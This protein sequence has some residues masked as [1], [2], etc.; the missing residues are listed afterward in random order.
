MLDYRIWRPEWH[1]RDYVVPLMN[2]AVKEAW[3]WWREVLSVVDNAGAESS[4]VG[5]SDSSSTT[6]RGTTAASVFMGQAAFNV[7]NSGADGYHQTAT[8]DAGRGQAFKL[9]VW[10]RVTTGS[11]C[12]VTVYDISNSAAITTVTVTAGSSWTLVVVEGTFPATCDRAAIRVGAASATAVTVWDNIAH[13]WGEI[14][15]IEGPSWLTQWLDNEGKLA[16]R[17]LQF[18]PKIAGATVSVTGSGGAQAGPGRAYRTRLVEEAEY[19]V[20]NNPSGA[21]PVQ[22]EL[23]SSLW[24]KG[25]LFIEA[26]RPFSHFNSTG[27]DTALSAETATNPIPLK[28]WVAAA[29]ML[30]AEERGYPKDTIAR[31]TQQYFEEQRKVQSLLRTP[32]IEQ[33]GL[34]WNRW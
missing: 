32:A 28:L 4:T 33:A 6:T 24:D 12:T 2:R 18:E 30:C 29:K 25:A 31:W 27:S 16:F 23:A 8:F 13:Y 1:P 21:N 15:L 34:A 26:K 22:L 9:Y 5:G 7:A 17:L 10:V 3:Q 19:Q 20:V 11:A 14:T